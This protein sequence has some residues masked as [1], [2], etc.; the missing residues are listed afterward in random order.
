MVVEPELDA[1]PIEMSID[2]IGK[3]NRVVH[4]SLFP[5]LAFIVVVVEGS[6]LSPASL[7]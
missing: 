4:G 5:L 1:A 3:I 7:R 6:Y 2:R